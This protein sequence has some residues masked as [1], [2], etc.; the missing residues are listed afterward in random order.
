MKRPTLMKTKRILQSAGLVLALTLVLQPSALVR[1]ATTI[2]AGYHY[3][4][5]ANLGWLECRGD[6][7]NGAVIGDYVC[8]GYL[9]TANVGWINLG[10]GSPTNGIRYQN[11]AASDFG[12]NHDAVGNLRGYAW[13]AIIGWVAF[14]DTG[15]PTVNL[16]TGKLGGYAYSANCGWISLSNALAYAQTDSLDPGSLGTNGLPV[17]WMLTYFGTTNV[18][19][20]ADSDH[21]GMSNLQEYLADTDPLDAN[22]CLRITGYTRTGSYNTLWWTSRPT[23][24]YQVQRHGPLDV[25]SPWETTI[26]LDTPGANNVGF[27][28][29]GGQYYYRIRAVR[30]LAP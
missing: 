5:G 14:E 21:D 15:A 4:Y 8:S 6:V 22:D 29:S 3:G 19:P 2:D 17:A 24:L 1:A 16:A 7:A 20:N 12:V 13:G 23:R 9:Y 27:D 26:S 25:A 28:N 30:P 10:S 11:L 18:N